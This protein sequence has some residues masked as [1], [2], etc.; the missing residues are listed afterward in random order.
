MNCAERITADCGMESFEKFVTEI[1]CY[2]CKAIPDPK[3]N[4]RYKYFKQHHTLC[5]GC[6]GKIQS[7]AGMGLTII[8]IRKWC[9]CHF[10][11]GCREMF[12]EEKA[13][14]DHQVEC[15][16]RQIPCCYAKCDQKIA[17]N[18]YLAHLSVLH[19]RCTKGSKQLVEYDIKSIIGLSRAEF[20]PVR[21]ETHG[22]SFF[23]INIV[24]NG[25]V[26]MWMLMFSSSSDVLRNYEWNLKLAGTDMVEHNAKGPP[27]PI[28]KHHKDVM[29]E[30]GGF[31]IERKKAVKIQEEFGKFGVMIWINNLKEETKYEDVE[32]GVWID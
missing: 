28:E 4:F 14:T 30:E 24:E 17:F 18:D 3:D 21:F 6:Y 32:L 15:I 27:L 7:P 12:R 1:Q 25:L 9:C 16:Y 22:N 29:D 8:N 10:E 23:L 11:H 5:G 13:L 31:S 19:P 20:Y 2:S 26:R